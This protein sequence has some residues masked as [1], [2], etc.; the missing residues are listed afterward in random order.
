MIQLLD[1]MQNPELTGDTVNRP[2]MSF[3]S[4]KPTRVTLDKLASICSREYM[5][6]QDLGLTALH[7]GG[8]RF[9]RASFQPE[10]SRI[11]VG[12]DLQLV[13][14]TRFSDPSGWI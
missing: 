6:R 1:P 12:V 11:G 9:F 13:S 3:C 2:K 8:G 4:L 14:Q 5:V 10:R 7:R